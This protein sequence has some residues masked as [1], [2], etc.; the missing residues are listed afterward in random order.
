MAVSHHLRPKLACQGSYRHHF[1]PKNEILHKTY[2]NYPFKCLYFPQEMAGTLGTGA[3]PLPL[4]KRHPYRPVL[5][6]PISTRSSP[7]QPTLKS[8]SIV[9]STLPYR[10]SP[11]QPHYYST[12]PYGTVP[13]E[14]FIQQKSNALYRTWYGQNILQMSVLPPL[15]SRGDN[16]VHPHSPPETQQ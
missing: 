6:Q 11:S 2:M 3:S 16:G 1:H 9:P 5:T 7:S 8:L 4:T 10:P 13:Y 15:L 14:I 12:L